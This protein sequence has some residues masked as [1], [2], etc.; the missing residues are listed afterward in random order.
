M[1]ATKDKEFL[2]AQLLTGF[3]CAGA[4]RSAVTR[5]SEAR[6]GHSRKIAGK[7]REAKHKALEDDGVG[8]VIRGTEEGWCWCCGCL[9]RLCSERK[10]RTT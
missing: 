10:D 1:K 7:G 5:S 9:L 6:E 8:H 4:N 3:W 2:A